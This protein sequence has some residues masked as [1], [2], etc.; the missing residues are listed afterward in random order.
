VNWHAQQNVSRAEALM[1]TR[2]LLVYALVPVL[3]LSGCVSTTTM[4]RTWGDPYPYGEPWARTGR[5]S[6]IRETVHRSRGNPAAGA[7]AGAAIGGILGSMLGARGHHRH[8]HPSA[9]G[10]VVGAAGGAMVG[11]VVSQG[12]SEERTYEVFVR[13]DDGGY[14]TFVYSG[15]APFR[16]GDAVQLTPSGLMRG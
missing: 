16:V 2:H 15:H 13:F 6:S 9:A 10:A 12:S 14:E 11:A 7:V 3:V 1:R 4:T 8:Y 5:V